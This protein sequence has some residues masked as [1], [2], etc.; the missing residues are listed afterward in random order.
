MISF[1]FWKEQLW[2]KAC[3]KYLLFIVLD[4]LDKNKN[5]AMGF[6]WENNQYA[7]R[8]VLILFFDG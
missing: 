4:F 3:F 5:D 2:I 1:K 6:Y 8:E 7:K